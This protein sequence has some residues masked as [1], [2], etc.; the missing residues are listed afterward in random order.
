MGTLRTALYSLF[1]ALSGMPALATDAAEIYANRCAF[2]HGL[3]GRGDGPAGVA[4]KPPPRNMAEA[5]YWKSADR[6]A[7]KSVIANGKPGTAMIGYS[8]LLTAEE[9]DAL[10]QY[11]ETFNPAR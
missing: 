8:H 6:Q 7:L 9:I 1:L 10:V 2:C 5:E 3:S 4:L 11:L